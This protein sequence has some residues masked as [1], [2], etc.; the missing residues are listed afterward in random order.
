[1]RH[2]IVIA[3]LAVMATLAAGCLL[4]THETKLV[5]EDEPRQAVAF[6]SDEGMTEFHAAVN[7]RADRGARER[8]RSSFNVPFI[9]SA[10]TRKVLSRTAFFNDQ[11]RLAD[12][13]ADGT[14]SDVEVW[15]Y[16]GR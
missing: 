3:A 6:E 12:I 2:I 11:V 7:R 10:N 14:L 15:A 1:M 16:D 13:N 5:R 8:G 4:T 9:V